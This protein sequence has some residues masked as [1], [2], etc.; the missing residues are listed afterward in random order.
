MLGRACNILG[1]ASGAAQARRADLAEMLAGVAAHAI[2]TPAM[3]AAA[4]L[5]T[6]TR[7]S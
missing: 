4:N 5:A 2:A 1:R 7:R 3:A 6:D